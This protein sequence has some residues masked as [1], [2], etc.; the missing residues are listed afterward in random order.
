MIKF[1]NALTVLFPVWAII[2][3]IWAFFDP[4][5]WLSLK[6]FIVPFL[7]IV[8]FSMGLTL[9][10]KDFQI[11]FKNVKTIFI[12]L[13]LQ[14][15]LMPFL[16]FILIFTFDLDKLIAAGVLLVGCAPG[17][18]ASNLI[19]Y[20]AK[21]NVALSISLTV[22]STF[23]AIIFMPLLFWFYSGNNIDVPIVPM[24]ISILK[25][26]I[27]P[28]ALGIIINN[29][30]LQFINK[31]KIGL[32]LL[33]LIAILLIIA[34]IIGSNA[35]QIGMYISTISLV[36][37][38]HNLIGLVLSYYFCHLLSLDK[39]TNRTIAIEIAMQNSGLAAA[40]AIKYFGSL[41]A[42]PAAIYSIWHNVSGSIIA[43][44]WKKN[45]I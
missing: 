6:D 44:Y 42:I 34:T 15:L 21:G 17:G 5:P 16:G 35:S 7:S 27:F 11:I 28:V 4:E 45:Y 37:I 9:N 12:G 20:L 14:F 31:I 43:S 25:I 36:I 29:L 2:F 3:S 40:I 32:P 33:A 1:I 10:V 26:I 18:T 23:L 13:L 8:M 38:L 39:K 41:A 19:C 30:N 24:M 22:C